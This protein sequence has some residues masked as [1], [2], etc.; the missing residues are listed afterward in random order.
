MAGVMKTCPHCEIELP[1][2]SAAICPSCGRSLGE[3]P[4]Q[5]AESLRSEPERVLF[6]GRPATIAGIGE[7]FVAIVT[8]GLG[9]LWLWVRSL[10]AYYRVTTSR[11]VIE[12][13]LFSKRL[14]QIDLYRVEDYVVEMPF[15]QRLLGTGNLVIATADRTAKGWVRLD[16][17]RTDVRRLY[18]ELRRA[19]EADKMRRGVRRMEAV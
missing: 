8:L 19:T 7:V 2:P 14:E 3:P 15:G 1:Q 18:E 6:E 5:R 12:Q 17:L 13:G 11:I 10:S 9:L 4:R 16:R